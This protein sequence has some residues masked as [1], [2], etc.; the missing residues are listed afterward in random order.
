MPHTQSVTYGMK[1]ITNFCIHS[2]NNL[3]KI[4]DK[5]SPL[6]KHELKKRISDY[7]ISKYSLDHKTNQKIS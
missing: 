3:A 4:V 1:S 6:S 7:F 5:P 2:W